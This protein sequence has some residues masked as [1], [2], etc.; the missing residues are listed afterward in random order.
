ML[1]RAGAPGDTLK[2]LRNLGRDGVY[3]LHGEAD[4]NVPVTEARAMRKALGTFHSDF[5]YYERPGAGH[6]WGSECVDWPP[7]FDF[8]ERHTQPDSNALRKVDFTTA[9]PG[10]S[11]RCDW[12]E[13]TN[14]AHALQPSHIILTLDA[15]HRT[16]SGTTENV[17]RLALNCRALPGDK[18]IRVKI[19][20]QTLADIPHPAND[21]RLWLVRDGEKWSIGSPPKSAIKNPDRYGPFKDAF[22]N[23]MLFVYGTVGTPEEN[24]AA[25]AKA[26]FDA[27]MFWYRGNASVELRAD[28]DFYSTDDIEHSVI[29]YGNADTNASWEQLLQYAPIAVQ[30]GVVRIGKRELKGADLACLFAVPRPHSERG[31]VAAVSGTG[32]AGLRLTERIPYFLSGVGVPDCVVLGSDTLSRGVAGVR[33]AGFFGTD[34]KVETGDWVWQTSEK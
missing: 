29:L 27:E 4:D 34:W 25:F 30:R 9:S 15:E 22:R 32:L 1:Q 7:L 5:V 8:L 33:V 13:I 11:S 3:V 16:I 23:H 18:P 10:V 26:R 20:G 24:A 2:L 31:M 12:A 14:Q 28:K 19:D 17:T 21:T 6:W